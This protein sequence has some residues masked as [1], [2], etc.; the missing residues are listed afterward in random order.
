MTDRHIYLLRVQRT[1]NLFSSL[2][3]NVD[4]C[5]D[6]LLPPRPRPVILP[7]ANLALEYDP[8]WNP[9]T[10]DLWGERLW[11]FAECDALEAI[12]A[13]FLQMSQSGEYQKEFYFIDYSL[14]P[15]RG[16][17]TRDLGK[18]AVSTTGPSRVSWRNDILHGMDEHARD[19]FTFLE[20]VFR[21]PP[22][23]PFQLGLSGMK[24]RVLAC[25]MP[26]ELD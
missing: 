1:C 13:W 2:R 14:K 9:G 11:E 5:H 16:L 26:G 24:I 12:R 17:S 21:G 8:S 25:V 20:F 15:R 4:Q 3:H 23:R 7:I 10:T 6:P 19:L 22:G 18:P